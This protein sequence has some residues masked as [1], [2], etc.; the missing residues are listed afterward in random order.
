M[1]TTLSRLAI[2]LL[3]IM[4]FLVVSFYAFS[5]GS[6][7]N[8][9]VSD[10]SDFSGVKA[11][12]VGDPL[13]EMKEIPDTCETKNS[14]DYLSDLADKKTIYDATLADDSEIRNCIVAILSNLDLP[15]TVV[16]NRVRLFR[17]ESWIVQDDKQIYCVTI[18][19]LDSTGQSMARGCVT[20]LKNAAAW[21]IDESSG[22]AVLPQSIRKDECYKMEEV[23]ARPA[24]GKLVKAEMAVSLSGAEDIF[25]NVIY[26]YVGKTFAVTLSVVRSFN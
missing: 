22:K 9:S 3:S 8:V 4:H 11:A 7:D 10:L 5:G 23:C 18:T 19:T 17:N 16:L 12:I 6:Q 2:V 21:G 24:N 1:K 13:R 15:A 26:N 20:K 25:V 14:S